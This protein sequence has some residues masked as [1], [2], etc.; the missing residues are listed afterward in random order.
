M[1]QLLLQQ[2]PL[3]SSRYDSFT[4]KVIE[5]NLASRPPLCADAEGWGPISDTRWDLTPC[6]LDIW[7]VAVAVWGLLGGAGAITYLVKKRT[8]QDVKKNWHYYAKL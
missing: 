7:L 5:S 2:A 8:P 6:F 3:Q 1:K 4:R